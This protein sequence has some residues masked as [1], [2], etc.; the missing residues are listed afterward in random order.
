VDDLTSADS[1]RSGV[2]LIELV[3]VLVVVGIMAALAAPVGSHWAENQRLATSIRG[4]ETA[5]SYAHGEAI[6][7]GNIHAVFFIA[8]A[9]ANALSAPIVV[10]NDGRAG[11][12][13][14]NCDIDTGEPTKSFGLEAGVSFG[15]TAA[16]AKVPTDPGAG[17]LGASSFQDAGGNPATWVLFRPEGYPLAFSS[18]CS[19]GAVGTGGGGVY[20]TNG[21][22]DVALVV[23]PLG[24]TRVHSWEGAGGSW[25]Q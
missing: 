2:T 10:L 8:D 23:T 18:D 17:S 21:S 12:S 19:I 3:I 25:T 11:A 24:A 14:Q 9:D 13:G 4:I 1:R 6:R 7:T 22:R 16:T 20:L 15:V 5:F